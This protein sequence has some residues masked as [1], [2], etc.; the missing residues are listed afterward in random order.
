MVE[1]MALGQGSNDDSDKGKDEEPTDPSEHLFVASR[2]D[3]CCDATKELGDGELG[4]PNAVYSIVSL[5]NRTRVLLSVPLQERVEYPGS[6]NNFGSD[7]SVGCSRSAQTVDVCIVRAEENCITHVRS[8]EYLRT[9][10]ISTHA[11]H[12]HRPFVTAEG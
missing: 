3:G 7:L 1:G 12:A 10:T 6:Q 2:P 4:H 5:V 9:E 8:F 11:K